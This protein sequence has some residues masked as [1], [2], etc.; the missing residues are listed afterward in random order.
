[1]I[2]KNPTLYQIETGQSKNVIKTLE[3]ISASSLPQANRGLEQSDTEM[4][5]N[6]TKENTASV[7]SS[8]N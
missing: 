6:V 7:K 5:N 2:T 8:N 4:K 3:A 1:M